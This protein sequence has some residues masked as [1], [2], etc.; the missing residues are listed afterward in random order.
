LVL[1]HDNLPKQITLLIYGLSLIMMFSAS[2]TYHLVQASPA[3]MQW[4]RKIDHSAIYLLIAGTYTPICFH[5]F[6]GF[7]R[8]GILWIIW[9]MAAVGIIVKLVIIHAPRWLTAAVYLG[10]GWLAVIGAQEMLREMPVSAVVWMLLGGGFFTVG[11]VV[12]ILKKPNIWPGWFGFHELW[13]I[14]VILGCLSFF[15]MI[16]AYVAIPGLL[17]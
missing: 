13:H 14:F 16:T 10:M 11:A 7:Y 6:D 2:A 9:V 3:V 17:G 8:W 1:A 5:F 12:Y 15:I 4:L